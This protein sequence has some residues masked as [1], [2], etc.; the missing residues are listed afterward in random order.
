M[1]AGEITLYMDDQILETVLRAN[2]RASRFY[3]AEIE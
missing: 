3:V 2:Y 1:T